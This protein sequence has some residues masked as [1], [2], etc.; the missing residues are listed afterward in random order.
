MAKRKAEKNAVTKYTKTPK[1]NLKR[2][3]FQLN[4]QMEKIMISLQT[5]TP[6]KEEKEEKEEGDG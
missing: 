5:E 3:S 2:Q 1:K 6:N 4:L